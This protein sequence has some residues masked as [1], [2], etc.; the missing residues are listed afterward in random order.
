MTNYLK[1]I[2]YTH[3]K[4]SLRIS[5]SNSGCRTSLHWLK[6]NY[7]PGTTPSFFTYYLNFT[8]KTPLWGGCYYYLHFTDEEVYNNPAQ[9]HA[10]RMWGVR[11]CTETCRSPAYSPAVPPLRFVFP[12]R[13]HRLMR[14]WLILPNLYLAESPLQQ[15][16]MH[17]NR[18]IALHR[19]GCMVIC[20]TLLLW[21]EIIAVPGPSNMQPKGESL[22][23]AHLKCPEHISLRLKHTG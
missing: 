18:R 21:E 10:S 11:L 2:R 23:W 3:N 1:N 17:G 8:F 22:L 7:V 6:A 16:Q 15:P 19:C 13:E 12:G 4:E 5:L 9:D 20:Y 14:I